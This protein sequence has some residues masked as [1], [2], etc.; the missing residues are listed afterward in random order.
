M[1]LAFGVAEGFVFSNKSLSAVGTAQIPIRYLKAKAVGKPSGL[2]S[3]D[4]MNEDGGC[5]Q[6][7]RF[8]DRGAAST[9]K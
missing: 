6:S 1:P 5:S 2:G 9:A 8:G 3:S 7:T 4:N